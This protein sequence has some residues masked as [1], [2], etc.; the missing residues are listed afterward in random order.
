MTKKFAVTYEID[1]THRVV[2]GVTAPNAEIAKQ[3]ASD[4]FDQ[5]SIWD[6][7]QEMPLLFDDF[8]EVDGETLCFSAEEVLEFPEPDASVNAI[9]EKEFAF[10]ACRLCL[11][12][13]LIPLANLR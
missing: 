13:K 8:E 6:S 11:P 7:T 9:K 2:V 4:A 5:G 1:Y 3:L 12:V 10:C